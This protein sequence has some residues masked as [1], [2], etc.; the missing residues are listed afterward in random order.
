M[1]NLHV[2]ELFVC[3][4]VVNGLALVTTGEPVRFPAHCSMDAHAPTVQPTDTPILLTVTAMNQGEVPVIY[5]IGGPY[6]DAGIFKARITNAQG[7]VREM[8][9]CKGELRAGSRR[10]RQLQPGASIEIPAWIEP[11]SAGSYTIQVGQGK[12]T[13]VTVRDDLD[14]ARKWDQDLLTK[15]R[16]GDPFAND[17]SYVC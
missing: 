10:L 12:S 8:F 5:D 4:F 15:I 7:L 2:M 14:I 17:F 1:C 3:T 6:L 16:K 13:E 11:L 9:L